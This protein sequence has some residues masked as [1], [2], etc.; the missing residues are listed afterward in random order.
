MGT[1]PHLAAFFGGTT[2]LAEAAGARPAADGS[3]VNLGIDIASLVGI[4]V[5]WRKDLVSR[6]ARV[7]RIAAGAAIALLQRQRR[8][9]RAVHKVV[10][11][12]LAS[13]DAES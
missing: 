4:G 12:R 2:L 8:G 1:N 9:G 6:E 3:L 11:R 10:R 13:A 5:A 7:R